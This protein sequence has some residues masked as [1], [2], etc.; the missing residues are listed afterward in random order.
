[1]IDDTSREECL[2]YTS[3]MSLL[4]EN[5]LQEGKEDVSGSVKVCASKKF[6]ADKD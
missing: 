3:M 6:G 4:T 1:M 5:K 2:V